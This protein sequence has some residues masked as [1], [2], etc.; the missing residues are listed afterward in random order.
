ML[1]A[2]YAGLSAAAMLAHEGRSVV[3][4]EQ[5]D[6]LGGC[7][8]FF[9][10]GR[11]TFDVG[12]TTL[13]GLQPQQPVGRLYSFLGIEPE[14]DLVDPGMAIVLDGDRIL[15]HSN[16]TAW[17]DELERTMPGGDHKRFWR[18]LESMDRR[19]YELVSQHPELPPTNV[20]DWVQLAHPRN[21]RAAGLG[22]A[23]LRPMEVLL[24]RY[25]FRHNA[26]FQR[27]VDE[28]L[29]I[30]TQSMAEQAP[31]LTGAMG[32]M[33]PADTYYPRGG[34]YRPAL[35][36][37]RHAQA[38]GLR[39]HFRARVR[40]MA[41]RMGGW[42]VTLADGRTVNAPIVVSS[43]PI[44]NMPY[45]TDG[46]VRAWYSDLAFKHHRA[47]SAVTLYAVIENA[48]T[49]PTPYWQI[50]LDQP[51]HGLRSKSIFVT[52]SPP[53]DTKKAPAGDSTL[54][55]SAHARWDDWDDMDADTAEALREHLA[56]RIVE[57]IRRA[58]PELADN[59]ITHV[60]TGT[61]FTWM[62]YTS[63]AEGRVG[64]IPHDIRSNMLLLP[65][66]VTPFPGL[67]HI[68]DTAFPGQG[69]PAVVLGAWNAVHRILNK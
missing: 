13:S 8:S 54:T 14:A 24:N 26:R 64:G 40:R 6:T 63:R 51:L 4:L 19:A 42:T 37:L 58:I 68:G 33:Y 69:T 67:Y 44:W 15:R 47:W 46:N 31:M 20:R 48:P 45:L 36:L 2:G 18:K 62:H 60:R 28:Q 25:G 52:I 23:T 65:P 1:G 39:A 38:K 59:T 9:R 50:H 29:L 5:H 41:L 7:A 11:Y 43:I 35:Q 22:V 21:W 34:M 61:P 49:L 27:F 30:S 16:A 12:A 32:L 3:L 10:D 57:Q 53:D 17:L 55:V 56:R 66:N